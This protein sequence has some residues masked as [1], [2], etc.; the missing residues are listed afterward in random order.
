MVSLRRCVNL[1]VLCASTLLWSCSGGGSTASL[2]GITTAASQWVMAWG[3]SPQNAQNTGDDPGG[4]EQ[5]FRFLV[6]PSIGATQERVHFSNYFGTTPI[7]I[8]AARVAVALSGTGPAV[9]ATT[10]TP[11]TF[12]GAATVT[13]QPKQE[14]DSDPVKIT[15]TFGQ[16]LAVSMYV[17][18]TFPALT[19][20]ASLVTNNYSSATGA[21]NTT[22]DA[23]GRCSRKRMLSGTW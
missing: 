11:L 13:L 19:E 6:L 4:S 7:T 2:P 9:N 23:T 3:V 20:H 5:S 21:G 14:I 16:W 17:Q 22:G 12:S 15:Y 1:V 18:G 8:G 10:D